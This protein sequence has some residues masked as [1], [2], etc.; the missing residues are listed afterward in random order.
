MVSTDFIFLPLCSQMYSRLER[1]L[2]EGE[3][4]VEGVNRGGMKLHISIGLWRDTKSDLES[5]ERWET[6]TISQ[7][8]MKMQFHSSVGVRDT[9]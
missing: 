5:E 6:Q 1:S 2:S 3:E 9:K 4:V 7:L 8:W